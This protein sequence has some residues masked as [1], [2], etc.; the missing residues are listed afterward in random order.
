VH[1][2]N[3]DKVGESH[4]G[5]CFGETDE[6]FKLAGCCCYLFLGVWGGAGGG[7]RG[8]VTQVNVGRYERFA[9]FLG[10]YGVDVGS[11]I[12]YVGRQVSKG[13]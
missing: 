12:C 1:I 9:C 13:L 6:R 4:S 10:N 2:G 8:R 11:C 5:V 3:L 7:G